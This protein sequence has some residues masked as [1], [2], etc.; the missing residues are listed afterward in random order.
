MVIPPSTIHPRS[1]NQHVHHDWGPA[2]QG[3]SRVAFEVATGYDAGM[4]ATDRTHKDLRL[5]R[6]VD[7]ATHWILAQLRPLDHWVQKRMRHDA[8]GHFVRLTV[9][10]VLALL[11]LVDWT[12]LDRGVW[13][14]CGTS[15]LAW[16]FA[17]NAEAAVH[18]LDQ[19]FRSLESWAGEPFDTQGFGFLPLRRLTIGA[20]VV[21]VGI[22]G[23]W[24]LRQSL[25]RIALPKLRSVGL[26][27][28]PTAQPISRLLWFMI[29]V[30]QSTLGLIGLSFYWQSRA[31]WKSGSFGLDLDRE[32][33]AHRLLPPLTTLAALVAWAAGLCGVFHLVWLGIKEL[34]PSRAGAQVWA[35]TPSSASLSRAL[36]RLRST[37]AHRRALPVAL[38][39]GLVFSSATWWFAPTWASTAVAVLLVTALMVLVIAA[40]TT[41]PTRVFAPTATAIKPTPRLHRSTIVDLVTIPSGSFLMGSPPSEE[42]RHGDESPVHPVRLSAFQLTATPITESQWNCVMEPKRTIGDLEKALPRA[43]VSWLDAVRFCNALS[44]LE[45][46]KSAYV[47]RPILLRRL[48]W[49]DSARLVR[50]R[51]GYRLPTEAQWEYACR[52]GT[53]TRYSSG[54][55]M[56][57]LGRI[58]WF[59]DNSAGHR[60]LVAQK[61]P[62]KLGLYDMH[63]NVWEWCQDW[64]GAYEEHESEDPDGPPNGSGRVL[65]G[66]SFW[67]GAW[68]CRSASR[69][70][71]SPGLRL[72]YV[73]F[74]VVLP[75]PPESGRP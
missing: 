69:S 34:R 45:G 52:A 53:T 54:N 22:L 8:Q 6:R 11:G 40:L 14:N 20:L 56:T 60:V 42:D 49:V 43:A 31:F 75:V 5:W 51:S 38:A 32:L 57:D 39:S 63:G 74:R 30:G 23:L 55:S 33:L 66:G 64:Y 41:R 2:G 48:P 65:R 62:N 46:L 44:R 9:P 68:W 71:W 47:I 73:G 16:E 15:F 29:L 7:A 18:A 21:G 3:S 19:H 37:P 70:G 27:D 4:S 36:Q 13:R 59:R 25:A 1:A 12:L 67:V 61:P 58:G 72:D 28:L 35:R 26:G 50:S 17:G 10:M 24:A